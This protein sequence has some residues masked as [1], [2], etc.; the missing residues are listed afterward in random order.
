[1]MTADGWR[2]PDQ[3]CTLGSVFQNSFG[4][5]ELNCDQKIQ[6]DF[7]NG[8]VL[9]YIKHKTSKHNDSGM[10]KEQI[11]TTCITWRCVWEWYM[12]MQ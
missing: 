6:L 5:G 12:A 8:I 3:A 4:S 7:I 11:M 10:N 1:M 2:M 9:V